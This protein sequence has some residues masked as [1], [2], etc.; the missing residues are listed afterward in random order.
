VFVQTNESAGNEIDVF[1]RGTDGRLTFASS[2]PTGGAG[3]V[4]PGASGRAQVRH[5]EQSSV[6]CW[7]ERIV[8]H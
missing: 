8:T 2:Y 3:G 7:Q 4:A 6:T 5:S 1:D